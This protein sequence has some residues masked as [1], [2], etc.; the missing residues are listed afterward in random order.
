MPGVTGDQSLY[1]YEWDSLIEKVENGAVLY[2]S[3]DNCSLNHFTE[4]FGAEVIGR[5]LRNSPAIVDLNGEKFTITADIKTSLNI[6]DAEVL[7]READGNPVFIRKKYGKGFCYLL[8]LPLEKSIGNISGAFH[9]PEQPAWRN[10]YAPLAEHIKERRRVFCNNPLVTLTEHPVNDE[11][12]W[13]IAIN[14]SPEVVAPVFDT[15]P[16][17]FVENTDN[18]EIKPFTAKILKVIKKQ[19]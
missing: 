1:G 17:W 19:Q 3:M 5:E 10:F 16:Q 13:V 12:C 14:N 6:I 2:I 15:N 9:K 18:V 8:T 4:L 11:H 7:A